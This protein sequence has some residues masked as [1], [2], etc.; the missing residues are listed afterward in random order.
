MSSV[1]IK[2]DETSSGSETSV[3]AHVYDAKGKPAGDIKLP[4]EIFAAPIIEEVIHD[5]VCWQ[6]DK[7]RAGTHSCLTKG[8][9]KGGGKKP[10]RQKGT[11]RARAGSSTS[12]IWVGGGVAH[13]PKPRS[14]A[15]RVSSRSRAQALAGVLSDKARQGQIKVVEGLAVKS[16]KTADAIKLLKALGLSDQKTLI[17]LGQEGVSEP[18]GAISPSELAFRN[19]KNSLTLPV[20]G[21][22]PYDVLWSST[23]VIARSALDQLQN[24]LCS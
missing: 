18:G 13:G 12:P 20:E 6:R 14:Y 1:E 17:V 16:G 22:N 8:A 7:L 23:L 10:W 15:S 5:S 11:G 19:V 24:R 2:A 4:P 3:S 9:M 21:L